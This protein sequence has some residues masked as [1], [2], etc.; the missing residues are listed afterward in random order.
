MVFC[1]K[2]VKRRMQASKNTS[3]QSGHGVDINPYVQKILRM[4]T[5][6]TKELATLIK[7]QNHWEKS[8]W[9]TA[10]LVLS[11]IHLPLSISKNFMTI[12]RRQ[13]LNSSVS[14]KMSTMAL[15]RW[16]IS[17]VHSWVCEFLQLGNNGSHKGDNDF[18]FHG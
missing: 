3:L 5:E 13:T 4:H 16:N 18:K 15:T 17:K 14:S 9:H 1:Y 10:G 6:A 12:I 2:S 11:R 7:S 8:G